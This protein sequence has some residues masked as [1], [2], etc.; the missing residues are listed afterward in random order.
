MDPI[1]VDDAMNDKIKRTMDISTRVGLGGTALFALAGFTQPLFGWW[2]SGSIMG[3]CAL[4]AGWGFWPLISSH[5]PSRQGI[6]DYWKGQAKTHASMIGVLLLG[7][8]IGGTVS[9]GDHGLWKVSPD[10]GRIVWNLEETASGHGYF[11]NM[12]KPADQEPRIVGFGAHGKNISSEPISD[13]DAYLRS[14]TTNETLPI[15]I[16]AAASGVT[17]ACS[18]A[19]PTLPKDTLGIPAFA[20]FDIVSYEKP[21]FLNVLYPDAVPLTKFL[22]EFVP[23]TL[24]MKYD[25]RNYKRHF[26]KEEVDRQVA[27]LEKLSAPITIPHVVRKQSAPTVAPPPL[28]TPI[29]PS[30]APVSP[31]NPD[32]TG[33]I[34]RN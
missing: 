11:L 1:A 19:A 5:L 15:Y 28:A 9:N 6:A 25:G 27:L 33:K 10:N 12:Q 22:N 29:P 2:I 16:V 4:V 7:L 8:G 17:N 30:S 20:D 24:V 34:P 23:F 26:S 32:V 14:D 18:M 3:I 13:F 31:A 21:F